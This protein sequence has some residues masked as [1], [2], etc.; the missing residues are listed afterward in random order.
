MKKVIFSLAIIVIIG[1]TASL[2]L[3]DATFSYDD[4]SEQD[5]RI[6]LKKATTIFKEEAHQ[7]K[8]D[9]I[10]FIAKKNVKN[11][12]N[13][14]FEYLFICHDQVVVIDPTTGKTEINPIKK[15]E[16]K[17]YTT[18]DVDAVSSIK[19]P[20]SAMKEALRQRGQ[21]RAKAKDWQLLI[22]NNKL[23]YEVDLLDDGQTQRLLIRA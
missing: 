7:E 2:G 6:S 15:V 1:I 22:K 4:I 9:A 18:F 12:T 19:T 11:Q 23:Y 16:K 3:L 8:V 13:N 21:K 20:Q 14:T 17:S 10:Q 5:Y